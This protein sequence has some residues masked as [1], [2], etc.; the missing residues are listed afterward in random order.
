MAAI[1]SFFYRGISRFKYSILW[2]NSAIAWIVQDD[3]QHRNHLGCGI[4]TWHSVLLTGGA[5]LE[6]AK[7]TARLASS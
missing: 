3:G 7:S 1:A 6:K 4:L 2:K 5:G